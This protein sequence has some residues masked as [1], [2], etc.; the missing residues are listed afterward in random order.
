MATRRAEPPR[1]DEQLE[2][3]HPL[4]LVLGELATDAKV[5]RIVLEPLTPTAVAQLAAPWEMNTADLFRKTGGN[6]FYV[7]EALLA[8]DESIPATVRDAVL[9]RVARLSPSA[10]RL[11][12]LVAVAQPET[13]CG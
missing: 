7:I 10:Q 12:E 3:S 8:Y 13:S 1:A 2:P 5:D 11:L 9:A 6:P 4:R